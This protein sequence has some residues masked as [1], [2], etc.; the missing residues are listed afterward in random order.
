LSIPR[1]ALSVPSAGTERRRG[2]FC[3]NTHDGAGWR[4]MKLA[5]HNPADD[6]VYGLLRRE[7]A[8]DDRRIFRYKTA[9]PNS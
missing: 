4:M 8:Q 5:T 7:G 3:G 9:P 6:G 1:A 2:F